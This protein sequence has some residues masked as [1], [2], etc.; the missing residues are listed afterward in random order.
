MPNFFIR[1]FFAP[2]TTSI[3]KFMPKRPLVSR[4][5]RN[6]RMASFV[7]SVR[8]APFV[9]NA[10]RQREEPDPLDP[11]SKTRLRACKCLQ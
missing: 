11:F 5:A 6:K 2:R 7:M 3:G 4:I 9:T 1:V 10:I 8:P